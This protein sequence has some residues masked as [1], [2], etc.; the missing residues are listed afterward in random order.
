MSERWKIALLISLVVHCAAIPLAFHY[1]ADP[2]DLSDSGVLISIRRYEEVASTPEQA[3]VPEPVLPVPK[4][5]QNIQNSLP[6]AEIKPVQKPDEPQSA[7]PVAATVILPTPAEPISTTNSKSIAQIEI[8]PLPRPETFAQNNAS[9]SP[10]NVV[11]NAEPRYRENRQPVY[12]P[13]ARRKR[14]EGLVILLVVVDVRG[15]AEKVEVKQGTGFSLLDNAAVEAVRAWSF[16]PAKVDN[17]AIV[18]S[19]EI[20]ISFKLSN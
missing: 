4:I 12:P 14:Q 6:P 9:P 11:V 15:T 16:E 18:S 20:P 1:S 8:T 2:P 10:P 13:Q 3:P 19:V 5:V 7:K 17:H